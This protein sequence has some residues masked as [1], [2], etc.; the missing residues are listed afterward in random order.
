METLIVL[1]RL[2]L[3]F[4]LAFAFGFARQKTHKPIGFGTFIFVSTGASA[5]GIIGLTLAPENPLPLLSAI[6]TGIGFLGAGAL[7][8]NNDRISGFTSA[9]SIWVFAI[10][11]LSIGIGSYFI[12]AIIYI[13]LWV[14]LFFEKYLEENGIGSYQKKLLVTT[15]K[16]VNEKEIESI[17]AI[18]SVKL[19]TMI[20]EVNK[21]DNCMSIAYL[22]Q[23][24]KQD[25]NLI[26]QRLYE[27]PW[28]ASFRV[29]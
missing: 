29:E 26:P 10:F 8:K 24:K 13:T 20:I 12:A 17:L 14:I 3:T 21:K 23:G 25:I 4:V 15:N 27:K 19:K 9:A 16:I 28:F 2:A 1:M 6:I 11:G 5:L 22:I 18:N 7:I